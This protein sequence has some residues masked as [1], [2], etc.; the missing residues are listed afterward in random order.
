MKV[1]CVRCVLC[2]MADR[3][4]RSQ[5]RDGARTGRGGSVSLSYNSSHVRTA[6]GLTRATFIP[7]EDSVPIKWPDGILLCPSRIQG[8]GPDWAVRE[9]RNDRQ[10]HIHTDRVLDWV[11]RWRKLGVFII[12]AYRQAGSLLRS[13]GRKAY[14]WI[15][16]T[17]LERR[18]SV[19]SQSFKL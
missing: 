19:G 7:Q 2:T 6:Q 18:V 10:L 16:G 12:V 13:T 5:V 11:L 17:G 8:V 14:S 9:W 15:K 3:M 4:E 1:L